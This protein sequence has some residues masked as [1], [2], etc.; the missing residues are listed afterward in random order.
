MNVAVMR[1][2]RSCVGVL[3]QLPHL[4]E[5][6][7]PQLD[8]RY[9]MKTDPAAAPSLEAR[10]SRTTRQNN[11]ILCFSLHFPHCNDEARLAHGGVTAMEPQLRFSLAYLAHQIQRARPV[12]VT[13]FDE[14]VVFVAKIVVADITVSQSPNQ[15]HVMI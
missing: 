9:V 5:H 13:Q 11:T 6:L 14:V 7:L 10:T 4:I 2:S 12:G 15:R 3:V 1:R 8:H